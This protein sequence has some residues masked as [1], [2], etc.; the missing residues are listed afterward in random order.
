MIFRRLPA[1]R[2]G[3]GRVFCS[4]PN[5]PILCPAGGLHNRYYGGVGPGRQK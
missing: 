4:A 3:M 5:I 1:G 2:M